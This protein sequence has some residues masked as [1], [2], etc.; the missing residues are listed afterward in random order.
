MAGAFPVISK[1][2]VDETG[3][4][5]VKGVAN[6]G[7]PLYQSLKDAQKRRFA[8]LAHVLRPHWMHGDGFGEEYRFQGLAVQRP[9]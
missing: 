9:P 4:I 5:E 8:F 7:A 3:G 6:A 2:R 1:V